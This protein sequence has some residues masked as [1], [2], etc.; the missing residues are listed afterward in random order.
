M[1]GAPGLDGCGTLPCMSNFLPLTG[2]EVAPTDAVSART[3]RRAVA[4]IF[5][6]NGVL[7]ANW[8]ARIPDVHHA[9]QLSEGTL[10]IAL[11]SMAVGA[12]VAQIA[13]GW[14]ISR[15]GSRGVTTLLA[16]L[17]CLALIL[18]GIASSLLVLM[19][20]LALFGAANG[21]LDVAMNAQAALVEER[22]AR[23]IMASFHGLWSIGGLLGAATG[24]LAAAR[25]MPVALH[26]LLAA[27]VGLVVVVVATRQLLPDSPAS[28]SGGPLVALPSRALLPLGLIAFCGLMSEGAIADWSAV[29]LR[30][31][32][33]ATPG[34]AAMGYAAFA[35]VMAAGRLCGDWLTSRLGPALVVRGGGVLVA[36]GMA[37]L[38]MSG[39]FGMAVASFGLIGAGVACLFPV[40]L[41]TAAQTPGVAPGT[42]IAAMATAG[43]TGFLVGPPLLG[44]LAEFI[45]L[46]GAL[47]LVALFGVIITVVGTL[48]TWPT[49]A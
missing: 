18:P 37:L 13:T 33:S 29:Y 40:V 43:Y 31:T 28:S 17:F 25:G 2:N 4:I 41:S 34:A 15:R 5:F 11:G 35:L 9:L 12:L 22:Y 49:R 19:L 8:I 44:V 47:G 26:F 3:A 1:S 30:D 23:P 6:T 36:A 16:L 24:G 21:G 10:G 48:I 7:I 14:Y 45:T 38:L 46:R 42:A 27:G 39:S 32:L 20:A